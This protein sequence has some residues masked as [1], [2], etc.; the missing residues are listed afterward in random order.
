MRRKIT[1]RFL[2]PEPESLNHTNLPWSCGWLCP[3][4]LQKRQIRGLPLFTHTLNRITVRW[5][6]TQTDFTR[7]CAFVPGDAAVCGHAA[8]CVSLCGALQILFGI[9]GYKNKFYLLSNK[10]KRRVR[11]RVN[12]GQSCSCGGHSNPSTNPVCPRWKTWFGIIHFSCYVSL[13]ISVYSLRQHNPPVQI[14][15]LFVCIL[16]GVSHRICF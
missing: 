10:H 9:P 1:R 15:S 14:R 3:T 13:D 2:L 16:C 11:H 12:H 7:T 6:P 4:Q 5:T 8:R